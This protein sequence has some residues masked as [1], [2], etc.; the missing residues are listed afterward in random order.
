MLRIH[1][2]RTGQVEA[3]RPARA[4]RMHTCGPDVHRVARLG[5]LRS[6]LTADLVRR[7]LERQRVR[8][9]VCRDV[10]DLGAEGGAPAAFE[11]DAALLNLRPPEHSPRASDSVPLVI[12][13]ITGLIGKGLAHPAPDG[14]VVFD[15]AASGEPQ[16]D[17]DWALWQPTQGEPAWDSPW[18]PGVP[19]PHAGCAAMSLRFLGEQVDLRTG[20][21]EQGVPHFEAV[22]ALSDAVAGHQVV[23]HW[24]RS[25]RLLFEGRQDAPE[26]REVAEAGLDPLAV[27]LA[28]LEHH[29]RRPL[30]LSWEALRAADKA[31]RGWR[32]RVAEW[33]ELPSAPMSAGQVERAE[34]AFYDDL[35][36]PSAIMILRE[37]E[38]D[39]AVPPGSKLESFLHLDQVLGLDLSVEIGR[40]PVR[41]RI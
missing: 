6:Q 32:G 22:R 1:D 33:A 4:M 26:L 29:Y 8:M 30:D 38:G 41:G 24:V 14:S 2:T 23:R 18:G 3:L 27:R 37:L 9:V 12:E 39:E 10:S 36:L 25:E 7:V 16:S 21:F 35:D 11:R 31:L 40:A 34:A 17:A 15:A 5:D 28:F 20:G 13:L 19:G